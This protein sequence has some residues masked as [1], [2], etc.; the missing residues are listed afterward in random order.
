MPLSDE[1]VGSAL[2]ALP[3]SELDA[4]EAAG[5]GGIGKSLD[6]LAV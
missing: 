6:M 2:L 3:G 4:A 1:S 5:S